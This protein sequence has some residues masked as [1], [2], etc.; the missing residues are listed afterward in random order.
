[1]HNI[2]CRMHA[3]AVVPLDATTTAELRSLGTSTSRH[4]PKKF[5][6]RD[7]RKSYI[8][9]IFL[10]CPFNPIACVLWPRRVRQSSICSV[11]LR[12]EVIDC[13]PIYSRG[14][15]VL[16]GPYIWPLGCR[17]NDIDQ[18]GSFYSTH[19]AVKPSCCM[20]R[21][22][23]FPI[24]ANA[25]PTCLAIFINLAFQ[26]SVETIT[27][28]GISTTLRENLLRICAPRWWRHYS[29]IWLRI[30]RRPNDS[31]WKHEKPT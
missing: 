10:P 16:R 23:L 11:K 2:T 18:P 14:V 29:R 5:L 27:P 1:M 22:C 3:W 9:N 15:F 19:Q 7:C 12:H 28:I 13:R 30:E 17:G 8:V 26:T 21:A 6:H 31:S 24:P 4:A 25:I 20:V